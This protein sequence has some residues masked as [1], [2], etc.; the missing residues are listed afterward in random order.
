[1]WRNRFQNPTQD[2]QG[3]VKRGGAKATTKKKI[4]GK[5]RRR[6]RGTGTCPS[7]RKSRSQGVF[8]VTVERT[9]TKKSLGPA[10]VI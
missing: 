4:C 5:I 1:M 6:G 7:D 10:S 2:E 9:K 8:E 3:E